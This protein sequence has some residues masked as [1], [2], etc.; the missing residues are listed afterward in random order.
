[1]IGCVE[2]QVYRGASRLKSKDDTSVYRTLAQKHPCIWNLLGKITILTFHPNP[3]YWNGIAIS[4]F[5]DSYFQP[6]TYSN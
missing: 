4:G 5:H 6:E 1:M 3:H 2:R